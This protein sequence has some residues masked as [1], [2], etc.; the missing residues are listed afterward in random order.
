[1]TPTRSKSKSF[2][3]YAF[4]RS[5]QL[6]AEHSIS[7]PFTGIQKLIDSLNIVVFRKRNFRFADVLDKQ[8]SGFLHT[9]ADQLLDFR[10]KS[11]TC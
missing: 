4:S 5:V 11:L 6:Q 1:M 8:H 7:I 3:L 2:S 9:V 10:L